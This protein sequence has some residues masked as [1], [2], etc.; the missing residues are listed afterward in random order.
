M[1][2][3][4]LVALLTAAAVGAT[5]VARL[6]V[7][8]MLIPLILR[9]TGVEGFS[10]WQL[11]N[12]ILV[13]IQPFDG[14]ASEVLK[15]WV[16]C[17]SPQSHQR[18]GGAFVSA[19]FA[20]LVLSIPFMTLAIGIAVWLYFPE[21]LLVNQGLSRAQLVGILLAQGVLTGLLAIP[22]SALRGANQ[23]Y[24][25]AG[26]TLMIILLGGGG[27]WLVLFAGFGVFGVLVTQLIVV[28][29]S[30]MV[31]VWICRR[32]V[33]WFRLRRLHRVLLWRV[34]SK[35]KW[36]VGSAFV[37]MLVAHLDVLLVGFLESPQGFSA[38][39]VNYYLPSMV[40]LLIGVAISSAMPGIGQLHHDKVSSGKLL[41]EI[42]SYINMGWALFS[43][44]LYF[45]ADDFVSFWVG[46]ELLVDTQLLFLIVALMYFQNRYNLFSL[47]IDL[48]L[49]PRQKIAAGMVNILVTVPCGVVAFQFW[50]L[51]GCLFVIVISR[52]LYGWYI[53]RLVFA[54]RGFVAMDCLWRRYGVM[55]LL[56]LMLGF[57]LG[58]EVLK[59]W[60]AL[61]V[62]LMA[63]SY[64]VTSFFQVKQ[65]L[66]R[67]I[68]LV[69]D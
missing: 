60:E 19:V 37:T 48:S 58:F 27:V 24:R 52:A 39:M 10:I 23:G 17:H 28:G 4:T 29:F 32:Y 49:E 9:T 12:R 1:T 69:I 45:L 53:E 18:M 8:F 43:V 50:G 57:L 42:V 33:S 26:V 56:A 30:L 55:I 47:F 16:A 38:Y 31:T 41:T 21:S 5:Q 54:E 51:V 35:A 36:F 7:S 22:I 14:R 20:N 34:S 44:L 67:R 15:W 6:L 46:Q 2:N 64:L 61:L 66:G 62:L 63:G 11:C 68:R 13:L 65:K 40:T 3:R 25:R 59:A